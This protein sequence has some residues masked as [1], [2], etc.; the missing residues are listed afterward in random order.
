[1]NRLLRN[2]RVCSIAAFSFLSGYQL[3]FLFEGAVLYKT[4][5]AYGLAPQPYIFAGII[6]IF[7][8]LFAGGYLVKSFSAAKLA[9]LAGAAVCLAA[10][11]P[12][13][14]AP[15]PL[16]LAGLIV[17]GLAVGCMIA[18]WGF[19]LKAF[20]PKGKRLKTC[21]DVLI[22]SL[23]LVIAVSVATANASHMV[24]LALSLLCLV[25]CAALTL[26]LSA[27]SEPETAAGRKP[28]DKPARDIKRPMIVLFLFV[29]IIT[30]DSGLMYQVI[31]PAFEHLSELTSWYFNVP[32][33]VAVVFMRNLPARISRS[34]ILYA[35]MGMIMAAFICFMLLRRGAA[36]YI[37]VNTL[38][39]GACGIFDLFW[40]SI[41]G[42]ALDYSD[43][44]A[45]TFGFGLSAN[46]LGVFLG[47]VLG[48]SITSIQLSGAE[49][50]VIALS[51]VCVTLVI[52]PPLNR[53]LVLLLKNHTYLSAYADMSEKQ[54][55]DV[56]IRANPIYPLTE[57]EREVLQFILGGK[58]NKDIAAAMSISEGTVKFHLGNIYS[59]YGVASRVELISGLL[60]HNITSS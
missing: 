49:V 6:A 41:L 29:A 13:F 5:S 56:I 38:M 44:P 59:K 3:S 51:V 23:L 17:A 12:F 40:W 45:K 39:V 18:S 2:P 19:F 52:L 15:S 26:S 32:Y 7:F 43:N 48:A 33:V 11:A 46:V 31:N 20:S 34:R 25:I 35:A 16:W 22:Y 24:G 36:D 47:G 42:E 28:S 30:I 10:T 14:F 21:A 57:R 4:L 58:T 60:R 53:Q 9:M 1:M 27:P 37:A 8:G 54:Q 55:S 50:A